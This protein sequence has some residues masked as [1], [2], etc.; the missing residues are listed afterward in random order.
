[1]FDESKVNRDKLG[2]FAKKSTSELKEQKMQKLK[3]KYSEDASQI[4]NKSENCIHIA[5]I[6][7]SVAEILKKEFNIVNN[8]IVVTKKQFENHIQGHHDNFYEKHKDNIPKI[9]KDPDFVFEDIKHDNGVIF[10]GV[11]EKT[12][13]IIALN[14]QNKKWSNTMITVFGCGKE[15][16]LRLLKK[17]KLFY[18][19]GNRGID[20]V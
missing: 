13:I 14:S 2:Q 7:P 15:T 5:D 20:N 19:K 8:E 9:I 18:K 16:L 12:Q 4:K 3:K 10:V 11:S 1:M 6:H 17:N